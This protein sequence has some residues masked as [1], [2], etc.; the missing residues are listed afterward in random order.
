MA[1]GLI[2]I[3]YIVL[4]VFLI[5]E[6]GL[7]AYLVDIFFDSPSSYNFMLFNTVWS[8]LILAYLVVA[9]VF[10]TR[11]Y[12]G[13]VALGLLVVTTI[14]WF[15]GSIAMAAW[16]GAPTCHST[17]CSSAQAAIA[18]GFFIW[19]IFMGLTI[20]EGLGFMRGRSSS[21]HVE[22]AKPGHSYP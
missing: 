1:V 8:F 11:I 7:L 15:S 9:T 18:F 2:S 6:L 14:F 20:V 16:L 19:A 21:S 5:I 13:L 3:A 22:T 4:L 10:I 17:P 12:H